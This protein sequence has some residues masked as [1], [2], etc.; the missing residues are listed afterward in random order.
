MAGELGSAS[1]TKPGVSLS[2]RLA[3]MV[4]C[5]LVYSL[6]AVVLAAWVMVTL[7]PMLSLSCTAVAV[8]VWRVF[9]FEDVK[10]SDALSTVTAVV[11]PLVTL[12]VTSAVG[13]A[14]RRAV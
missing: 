14:D 4:A 1:K 8:T 12:T 6:V 5:T 7:S 10:V 2:V 9:Q 11:S 13:S 3:V